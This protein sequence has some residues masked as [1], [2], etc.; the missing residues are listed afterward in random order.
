MPS[1]S[2]TLALC[3]R[4]SSTKPSVSASRWRFLPS[5]FLAGSNPRSFPPTP[6]V[7]S[8]WESTIDALGL[9]SLPSRTRK[10]SRNS[11]LRRFHV[12][13]MRHLLKQS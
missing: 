13:S 5:T 6:V 2:G 11:A 4:A 3:T 12:P 10:S 7:L 1:W 8:D 9:G